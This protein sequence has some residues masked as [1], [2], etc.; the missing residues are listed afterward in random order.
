MHTEFWSEN[1]KVGDHLKDADVDGRIIL[2]W[3]LQKWDGVHA[4]DRSGSGQGQVADSNDF[5]N[6]PLGAIK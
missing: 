5:G 3:I 1:L 4:L 2:Q 6:E